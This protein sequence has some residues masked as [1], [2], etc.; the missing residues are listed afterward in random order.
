MNK[1]YITPNSSLFSQWLA[2]K[3][4][5]NQYADNVYFEYNCANVKIEYFEH[6]AKQLIRCH[7]VLRYS[8]C[9]MNNELKIQIDTPENIPVKIKYIE[10]FGDEKWKD[11]VMPSVEMALKQSFDLES[12][13][14]FRL[15]FAR[16]SES[17]YK[18]V[19]VI[20][21][22]LVDTHTLHI[23]Y[24][25]T[26]ALIARILKG[27]VFPELLIDDIQ[28]TAHINEQTYSDFSMG[29][30]A[31]TYWLS[32]F[33][34]GVSDVYL[35]DKV[36]KTDV[37]QSK[38][39][40]EKAAKRFME[41]NNIDANFSLVLLLYGHKSFKYI[42]YVQVLQKHILEKMEALARASNTTVFSIM[43]SCYYLVI[44]KLSLN[45]NVTI[46]YTMSTRN[47][48][49][50]QNASGAFLN[51][52]FINRNVNENSLAID[53]I[54][55]THRL[56]NQMKINSGVSMPKVW[57]V[58]DLSDYSNVPLDINYFIN[59]H[60]V[61]TEAVSKQEG[62]H[63]RQDG[64]FGFDI[65][66]KAIQGTD[67]IVLS[68]NYKEAFFSEE[69]IEELTGTVLTIINQVTDSPYLPI[70]Y[71]TSLVYDVI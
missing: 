28:F 24:S 9:M 57:R 14:L 32:H 66:L 51:Q 10:C 71:K 17:D 62:A 61:I 27:E 2:F 29:H 30:Q 33:K 21:H 12:S 67:G 22:L 64:E 7:E 35:G 5:N 31:N 39:E 69:Y 53:F 59:Q 50:K 3:L 63:N 43:A 55:E 26:N 20:P 58:L 48:V 40:Y 37:V 46:G 68:Y 18:F 4:N 23:F 38:K 8:F 1:N 42:M 56:I 52:L 60:D 15:Y 11:E 44:H 47:S 36:D 19:F 49:E 13:P 70:N 25:E 45:S 16:L 6:V 34:G 65:A 54:K 41:Q